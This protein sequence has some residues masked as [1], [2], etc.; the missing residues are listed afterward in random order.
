MRLGK[1]RLCGITISNWN[2]FGQN[3]IAEKFVKFIDFTGIKIPTLK[4][5]LWNRN[6]QN[7]CLEMINLRFLAKFFNDSCLSRACRNIKFGSLPL[8]VINGFLEFNYS[9]HQS[10]LRHLSIMNLFDHDSPNEPCS[11]EFFPAIGCLKNSLQ[12]LILESKNGFVLHEVEHLNSITANIEHLN[13]EV[14]RCT[15]FN[16]L[17]ANQFAQ[18]FSSFNFLKLKHLSIGSCRNWFD[19]TESSNSLLNNL[20]KFNNVLSLHLSQIDISS[21]SIALAALFESLIIVERLFLDKLIIHQSGKT[22]WSSL[23]A[24]FNLCL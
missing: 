24:I 22:S 10:N 19:S 15:S 9:K 16:N 11:L 18:L 13:L 6:L 5:V 7:Q 20:R 14:F 2:Y 4:L 17:T 23:S 21:N 1:M 3:I 8:F 12:S